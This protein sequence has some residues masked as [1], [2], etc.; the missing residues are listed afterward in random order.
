LSK[1]A[2]QRTIDVQIYD[3]HYSIVLKSALEESEVR[4]LAEMVDNRMREIATMANT[5]DSLKVA[6][7]AALH[8]AQ[9]LRELQRDSEQSDA[10][11]R[12]KS[13]EWLLALERVIG[14]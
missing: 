14:K 2:R 11:I 1:P 5:A 4:S 7:L 8:F 10:L 12:K 9:D 6:V 13:D 3:Q